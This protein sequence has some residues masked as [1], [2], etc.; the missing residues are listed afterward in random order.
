M[1]SELKTLLKVFLIW[2]SVSSVATVV[3]GLL[4]VLNYKAYVRKEAVVATVP[5]FEIHEHFR[6]DSQSRAEI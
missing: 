2:N 3:E 5:S 4:G 1:F 6:H